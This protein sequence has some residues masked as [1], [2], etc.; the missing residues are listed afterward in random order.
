MNKAEIREMRRQLAAQMEKID[1]HLAMDDAIGLAYQERAGKELQPGGD[2]TAT[3]KSRAEEIMLM[4]PKS[5]LP[6]D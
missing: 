3:D 4:F 1:R 6:C 5:E 2:Y